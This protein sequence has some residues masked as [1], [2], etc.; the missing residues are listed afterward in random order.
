MPCLANSPS[1]TVIW[2]RPQMARPPQTESMSTPSVRAA[3]STGVPIGE[4][5]P[6]AGR[7]EDD[8][9]VAVSVSGHQIRSSAAAAALLA[10]PAAAR[11]HPSPGRRR[12]RPIA[13]GPG[14]TGRAPRRLAELAV[15]ARQFRSMPFSTLAPMMACM[16]SSC[17]GFMIAEVMPCEAAMARK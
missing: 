4:A 11:R 10:R 7:R 16:S 3:C 12:Q 15:Q 2:Q 9:G 17:S 5:P 6:L 13:D 8:Q 14:C 1:P